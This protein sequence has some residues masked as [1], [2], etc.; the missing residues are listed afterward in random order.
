MIIVSALIIG[1]NVGLSVYFGLS[2]HYAASAISAAGA[3]SCVMIL[4]LSK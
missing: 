3:A 1:F 2:G 4:S